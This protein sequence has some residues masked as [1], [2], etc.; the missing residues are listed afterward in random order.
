M[1]KNKGPEENRVTVGAP[2]P[3]TMAKAVCSTS[4]VCEGR[5]KRH[6]PKATGL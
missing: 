2:R 1:R 6:V 5:T 3:P 4:A